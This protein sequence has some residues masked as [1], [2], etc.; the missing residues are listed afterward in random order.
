V[1][2]LDGYVRKVERL[3]GIVVESRRGETMGRRG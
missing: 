3:Y 2:D 1:W